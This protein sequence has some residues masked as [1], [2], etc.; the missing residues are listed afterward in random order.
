MMTKKVVY[1]IVVV[2]IILGIVFFY[3]NSM[4]KSTQLSQYDNVAVSQGTL[5]RLYGIA[6]NASLAASAGTV[7]PAGIVQAPAN[8]T[9]LALSGK[10]ELLY[11]GADYCPYCASVRWGLVLA[12]MR[13][14]NFSGLHYMT[15][16]AT[17][18]YANTATFS[19]YNASYSSPSISFVEV[20]LTTNEFDSA[21]QSYP[22]LQNLTIPEQ[23][24]L[25]QNDNQGSI[26]FID[27]ANSSVSLGAPVGPQLLQGLNWTTVIQELG[28]PGSTLGQAM[29]SAANLY[30]AEIC[31]S[32]N[33]T[34]GVCSQS[35]VPTIEKTQ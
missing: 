29:I 32:I 22:K 16:S 31:K 4:P 10:P 5:A 19:F 25:Y 11:I 27:F 28:S 18:S 14:G 30:T 17:D 9:P 20:E 12:L 21:T 6:N 1:A 23:T 15:S 3:F 8:S 2:A 24:I 7:Y 13:F 26:P 33:N 35:Y 34:A